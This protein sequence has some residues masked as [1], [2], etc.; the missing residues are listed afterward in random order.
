MLPALIAFWKVFL[1]NMSANW[2]S[3]D[4]TNSR[5]VSEKGSTKHRSNNSNN[6]ERSWFGKRT[7]TVE[8]TALMR[9][10][11]NQRAWFSV[12]PQCLLKPGESASPGWWIRRRPSN[13]LL[14]VQCWC[15]N[16]EFIV[17]EKSAFSCR[18][19]R[20]G[21]ALVHEDWFWRTAS[22]SS[23]CKDNVLLMHSSED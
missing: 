7:T 1:R 13:S 19:A 21:S 2:F 5:F 17:L 15:W 11:Y 4:R 12:S 6:F 18:P 9:W 23:C 22:R 8:A 3:C 16:V 20:V 14:T 10:L